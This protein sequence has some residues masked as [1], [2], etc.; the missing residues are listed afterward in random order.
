MVFYGKVRKQMRERL[1][2]ALVAVLMLSLNACGAYH[3][4]LRTAH[5]DPRPGTALIDKAFPVT[6]VTEDMTED[7]AKEALVK[8]EERLD[9][10]GVLMSKLHSHAV[11]TTGRNEELAKDSEN[12]AKQVTTE[13]R[14]GLDMASQAAGT[15]VKTATGINVLD[16]TGADQAIA[17]AA[18]IAAKAKLKGAGKPREINTFNVS[19]DA[20]AD[21]DASAKAD[22]DAR[23]EGGDANAT[24]G[25]ARV[26]GGGKPDDHGNPPDG[27]PERPP[28]PGGKCSGQ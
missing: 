28:C 19:A 9:A 15:F 8:Y 1:I 22:A 21:A 3:A 7:A 6:E 4:R 13:A 10:S 16:A 20:D 12:L 26:T 24:G 27:H 18:V 5:E 2:T 11:L 17:D 14:T 23:A 25:G